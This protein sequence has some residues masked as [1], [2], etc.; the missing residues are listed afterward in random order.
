MKAVGLTAVEAE[1]FYYVTEVKKSVTTDFIRSPSSSLC[2][3]KIVCYNIFLSYFHHPYS[4]PALKYK[5]LGLFHFAAHS[6]LYWH[7]REKTLCVWVWSYACASSRL[8][9]FIREMSTRKFEI[10]RE[11]AEKIP[12]SNFCGTMIFL[13]EASWKTTFFT[14]LWC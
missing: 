5:S 8:L 10:C 6:L 13:L 12:D 4:S 2:Q 9:D 14:L 7:C 3:H 1:V 11:D